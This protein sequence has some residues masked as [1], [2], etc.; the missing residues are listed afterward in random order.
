MTFE[1]DRTLIDLPDLPR[2]RR[3]QP[4]VQRSGNAFR[5]ICEID[6]RVTVDQ[7]DDLRQGRRWRLWVRGTQVEVP[8]F[9][10]SFAFGILAA[11]RVPE[12][13]A[14]VVLVCGLV[15]TLVG[16]GMTAV[17]VPVLLFQHYSLFNGRRSAVLRAFLTDVVRLRK[18]PVPVEP[19]WPPP[20]H[21]G[22]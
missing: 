4:G 6:G 16:F 10:A 11:R 2:L 20:M 18:P 13:V 22:P 14:G 12:V 15:A 5:G 19:P 9:A 7:L 8:A 3:F 1:E 21:R 17:S